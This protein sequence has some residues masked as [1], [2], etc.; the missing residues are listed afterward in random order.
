[1]NPYDGEFAR[2][3]IDYLLAEQNISIDT[4]LTSKDFTESSNEQIKSY[5]EYKWRNEGYDLFLASFWVWQLISGCEFQGRRCTRN[6]FYWY[7]DYYYGN[8]YRFNG[9]SDLE[10]QTR[11]D[12]R[13]DSQSTRKA[14]KTGWRNGLRLSLTAGSQSKQLQYVYKNGFRII[15]H[16]QTIYSFPDQDGIDVSALMHTNIG[17]KRKFLRRLPSPYSDCIDEL[18]EADAAKNDILKEMLNQI[19]SNKIKQYQNDYCMAIC[20]QKFIVNKCKCLKLSL[21]S[22]NVNFYDEKGNLT[23]GCYLKTDVECMVSAD[24]EYHNS[25]AIKECYSQCPNECNKLLY[26]LQVSQ[27]R[28]PNQWFTDAFLID[29]E[30]SS[31][32]AVNIFYE[33]LEYQL[34][35]ETP[36]FTF[37]YLVANIGGY[38]SLFTG[39]SFLT[40]IE[41]FELIA[42]PILAAIRFKWNTRKLVHTNWT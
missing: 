37:D 11:R 1:M 10:N 18:S 13:Y 19:Q 30:E 17:I 29:K 42:S 36:Q 33:T 35:T 39:M 38:L 2:S 8:C 4:S 9:G 28:F 26:E 12:G 34:I 3:D 24:K 41:F 6:D 21:A 27:S 22:L 15:I 31:P 20:L 32:L 25:D 16:N 23:T 40:F 14:Y 5:F 7:H